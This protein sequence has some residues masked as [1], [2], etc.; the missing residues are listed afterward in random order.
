MIRE[1]PQVVQ[2]AN[3]YIN[4]KGYLGLVKK[5]KIPTLE[6]EMIESKSA[7]ST[8]YNAGVLKPTEL[9]FT[10]NALDKNEFLSFGLNSFV[11]RVPFLFK[12][13]IHQSGKIKKVP[14]S[15]AITGD[16]IS[17]EVADFESGKEIEVTFKVAAHF[18][19]INIDGVPM[20]LKDSE[21]MICIIGG[22]DY[23]AQV[24]ANL[25]E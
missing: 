19:D 1:V 2:E 7:L 23:M 3:A 21:N 6:W 12:A 17:M 5:L 11:N 9:E 25:A 10:I 4:G 13:S 22:M 20:V 8:N 24:R 18:V 16:I 15:M 14:F